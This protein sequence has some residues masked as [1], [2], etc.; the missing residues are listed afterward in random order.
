MD[1]FPETLW[2][3]KDNKNLETEKLEKALRI[4]VDEAT[5]YLKFSDLEFDGEFRKPKCQT[6][7]A[8]QFRKDYLKKQ[9]GLIKIKARVNL[10]HKVAKQLNDVLRETLEE[11]IDSETDKIGHVF[12]VDKCF[13]HSRLKPRPNGLADIEFQSQISDF[14]SSL[15][16]VAAING[17]DETVSLLET[18]KLGKPINM[19]LCTVLN[20][21]SGSSFYSHDQGLQIVPLSLPLSELP[22]LPLMGDTEPIDYL[23]MSL[24]KV[25]ISASPVLFKPKP[26]RKENIVHT[27]SKLTNFEFIYAALSLLANRY[28][29]PSFFWYEYSD[30][31]AFSQGIKQIWGIPGENR[32]KKISWKEIHRDYPKEELTLIP[33]DDSPPPNLDDKKLDKI[34][35][36]LY[37]N[38]KHLIPLSRWHRS[39]RTKAR[40]EDRFI[41]LRIALE[42][43]Y[44]RGIRQ[45]LKYRLY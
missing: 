28:I 11:F 6:L 12:L 27:S 35:N 10:P 31:S 9:M 36:A 30:A 2:V 23:G 34:I 24:L 19:Y 18:W 1:V 25:Q 41:D 26:D 29:S 33:K 4:A 42:A 38:D 37:P 8:E 40:L 16:R 44:I 22:R 21:L 15:V 13:S 17:I 5:F 3:K 20:G 39:M 45:E 14:A 32:L 7:K 43:L